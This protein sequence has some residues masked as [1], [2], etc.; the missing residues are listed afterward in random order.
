MRTVTFGEGANSWNSYDDKGL[1]TLTI[2]VQPPKPNY[3][4]LEIAGRDGVLDMSEAVAG[5]VTYSLAELN[6]AFRVYDDDCKAI[7]NA[8]IDDLHGKK[9]T[10]TVS[11]DEDHKYE[12]R[13]TVEIKEDKGY[14]I[15]FTI[16]AQ[17]SVTSIGA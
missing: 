17:A 15:D 3:V 7:V 2:D 16:E 5:R 13:C 12:G 8:I 6:F 10:I 4:Y 11:D 1:L 9:K 14:Y